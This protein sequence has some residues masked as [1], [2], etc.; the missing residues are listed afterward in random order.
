MKLLKSKKADHEIWFIVFEIMLLGVVALFLFNHVNKLAKETL[1]EKDFL[2]K[3]LALT[4]DTVLAVP[5][6]IHY[7]YPLDWATPKF[8][9]IFQQYKL[10]IDEKKEVKTSHTI[11]PYAND[12]SFLL[13]TI[14]LN[15]PSK[16]EF[17]NSG[18]LLNIQEE[19]IPNQNKSK[20]PYIET[21]NT[22]QKEIT[23]LSG[24]LKK[25]DGTDYTEQ[26]SFAEPVKLELN[27]ATTSTKTEF[28]ICPPEFCFQSIPSATSSNSALVLIFKNNVHEPD[29]LKLYIPSNPL[30]IKQSRKLAS[31]LINSLKE[32]DAFRNLPIII[33]PVNS[34]I[35][36]PSVIINLG[37]NLIK[38]SSQ[39]IYAS[40]S[41]SI[42]TYCT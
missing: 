15:I 3:D 30:I 20:Y 34:D 41:T 14:P 16:I 21:K 1:Y 11:F 26:N 5:G 37:D 19:I 23:L 38:T 10:S 17:E 35:Q 8:N 24:I 39:D 28:S 40:I 25:P 4:A 33:I 13:N 18:Y 12:L 9:Y 29:S 2:A 32:K 31:L 27:Q 6:N 42:R 36:T 7:S 22:C